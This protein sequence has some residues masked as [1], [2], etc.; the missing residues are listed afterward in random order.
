MPPLLQIKSAIRDRD[1]IVV[2]ESAAE[3]LLP[4]KLSPRV[5]SFFLPVQMIS[6]SHLHGFPS[7]DQGF[8]AV[9]VA[10]ERNNL[11]EYCPFNSEQK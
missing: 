7:S 8:L 6:Q 5:T 4:V 11:C 1:L 9:S 2:R 10:V 3:S